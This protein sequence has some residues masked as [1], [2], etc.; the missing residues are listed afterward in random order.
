MHQHAKQYIFFIY[1][2][3]LC[4]I[5]YLHMGPINGLELHIPILV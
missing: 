2:N 1:C 5:Y 3:V 4:A